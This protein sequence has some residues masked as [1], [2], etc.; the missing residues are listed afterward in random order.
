MKINL[1][2]HSEKDLTNGECEDLLLALSAAIQKNESL[3]QH[4]WSAKLTTSGESG[5]EF[6]IGMVSLDKDVQ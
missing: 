1:E 5:D 4:K 6:T 2:I 3:N